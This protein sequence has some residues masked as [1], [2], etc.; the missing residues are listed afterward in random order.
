MSGQK[1]SLTL[2]ADQMKK[3]LTD[4]ITVTRGGITVLLQTKD[5]TGDD[6]PALKS[7]HRALSDMLD[8]L[9]GGDVDDIDDIDDDDDADDD[10]DDDIEDEVD[11]DDDDDELE[12]EP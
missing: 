5:Y 4:E 6:I 10:Y 8:D 2:N 9:E 3:L 12:E 7:I 11:D 1:I